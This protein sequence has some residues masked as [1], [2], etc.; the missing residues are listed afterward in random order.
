MKPHFKGLDVP[1]FY[2]YLDKSTSYF[3]FGSGG[4][5]YQAALRNN[6]K[7]IYDLLDFEK[8]LLHTND[9]QTFGGLDE[10]CNDNYPKESFKDYKTNTKSECI[11]GLHPNREATETFAKK[12][13]YP[14]WIHFYNN[15][16]NE[17]V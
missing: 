3:E 8:M 6:I 13:L 16:K 7:S 1:M 15:I 2:K 11:I 12:Y 9:K 14:K 5:T 4:S 10:Y 17:E